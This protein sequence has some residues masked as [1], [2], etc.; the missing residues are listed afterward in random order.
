[1][2]NLTSNLE[3]SG[4][5]FGLILDPLTVRIKCKSDCSIR[6]KLIPG[7]LTS[8]AKSQICAEI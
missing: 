2:T 4:T 3:G 8:K 7:N 6:G 5:L 1:M